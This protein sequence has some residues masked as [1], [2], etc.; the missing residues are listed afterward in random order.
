LGKRNVDKREEVEE[1]EEDEEGEVK[2]HESLSEPTFM[3]SRRPY[4]CPA[5][6]H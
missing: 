2:E 6:Y 4:N 5:G 3:Q 1:A